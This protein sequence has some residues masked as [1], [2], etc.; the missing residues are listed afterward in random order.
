MKQPGNQES[1]PSWW[2]CSHPLRSPVQLR[3]QSDSLH[4]EHL[5]HTVYAN[6]TRDAGPESRRRAM[7]GGPGWGSEQGRAR[8]HVSV[9][10]QLGEHHM[11]SQA[12]RTAGQGQEDRRQGRRRLEAVLAAGAPAGTPPLPERGGEAGLPSLAVAPVQV[13]RDE[14]PLVVILAGAQQKQGC[15]QTRPR[16]APSPG[17]R[18][19]W[20]GDSGPGLCSLLRGRRA[21]AACFGHRSPA[22]SQ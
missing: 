17:R 10:W 8:E 13:G 16:V 12:A 21:Q 5:T 9:F 11:Q 4:S 1:P 22:P 18:W 6:L 15:R 7:V 14:G 20:T 19:A 3:S 2:V